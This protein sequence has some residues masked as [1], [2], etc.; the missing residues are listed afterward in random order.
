VR[1]PTNRT[2]VLLVV[3][4]PWRGVRARRPSGPDRP[5][6]I[7]VGRLGKLGFDTGIY[8]YV[9]S[10][11][12]PG[13]VAARLSRH[14]AGARKDRWHIDY[15]LGEGEVIGARGKHFSC[16]FSASSRR[17]CGSAARADKID[18]TSTLTSAGSPG[19]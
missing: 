10:A 18:V 5:I 7:R 11:L 16:W 13:G 14:I 6:E 3:D 19:Q 2:Y 9:G 12:G 15:L 4:G 1:K 8:A 17:C